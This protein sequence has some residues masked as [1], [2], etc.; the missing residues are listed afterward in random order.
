MINTTIFSSVLPKAFFFFKLE[1]QKK[2]QQ[3]VVLDNHAAFIT[4]GAGLV[5]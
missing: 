4:F 2:K 3:G 1:I 5:M